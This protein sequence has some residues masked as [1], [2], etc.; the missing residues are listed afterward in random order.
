MR[1][2][3]T[4]MRGWGKGWTTALFIVAV[5][6]V[7]FMRVMAQ[8]TKTTPAAQSTTART[9]GKPDFSG[10]WEANNTANWDLQT[11]GA[12][13]MVAQPGVYPNVPVLGAP[14]VALG[15]VGWVPPG[16]G[17]VE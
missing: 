1:G 7:L 16:M 6:G 12:R 11:H 9:A 17:V 4:H 8:G 14:V 13:P 5:A 2:G 10:I 3:N 15:T